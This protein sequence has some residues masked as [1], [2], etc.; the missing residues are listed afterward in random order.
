MGIK[1]ERVK[2]ILQSP[3]FKNLVQQRLTVSISLT[4]IMLVVYFGFIL[5]IAFYKEFLSIK[6]GEHL[7]LGLPIGIGLIIFAWLLTGFY[8][9]WANRKY[10]KAVRE[11]RNEVLEN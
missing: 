10:D 4:I 3:Q 2:E 5:S 1:P 9:R 7:T 8:I 11:L 6:I